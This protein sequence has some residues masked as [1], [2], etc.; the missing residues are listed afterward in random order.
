[1][2]VFKDSILGFSSAVFSQQLS[3]ATNLVFIMQYPRLNQGYLI[4]KV[5]KAST[6]LHIKHSQTATICDWQIIIRNSL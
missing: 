1:M 4:D 6:V 2:Q 5:Y 3:N